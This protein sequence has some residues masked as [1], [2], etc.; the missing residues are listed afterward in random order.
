MRQRYLNFLVSLL[1]KVL[2]IL[3]CCRAYLV[4]CFLLLLLL[5]GVPCGLLSIAVAVAGHTLWLAFYCCCCCW[6]TLWLAFY[7]YCCC[8]ATLWLAFYCCC[9]CCAY[10]VAC[11]LLLLL[12]L[13]VPCGLHSI[14]V[15][16]AVRTLWLAFYCCC[17]C[18]AYLVACI[19]LLLLLLDVPCGLHSIA[20]AIAG[21]PCGLHSIAVAVVVAGRALWL[22]L[23]CCCCCRAYLVAYRHAHNFVKD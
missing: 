13:G 10:L 18:W 22:A 4:A 15:A 16:V 12:L 9:C 21:L 3:Y 11:M 14:A 5:L 20:F 6:A 7:C 17:C 8:W 23:H 2:K 19:L 1:N